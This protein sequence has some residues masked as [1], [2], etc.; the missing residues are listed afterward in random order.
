MTDAKDQLIDMHHTRWQT[1][2][3]AVADRWNDGVVVGDDR[4]AVK[5]ALD[6]IRSAPD[7]EIKL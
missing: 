6:M 4:Q 1:L 7:R 3:N 2:V 5:W